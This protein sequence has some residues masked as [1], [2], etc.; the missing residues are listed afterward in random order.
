M[1]TRISVSTPFVAMKPRSQIRPG[2]QK[3]GFY[4]PLMNDE[5]RL[6][7]LDRGSEPIISCKVVHVPLSQDPVF[8][9]LSYTWGSL[10]NKEKILVNDTPFP[11]T[12]NLFEALL[13]IRKQVR[14][15]QDKKTIPL[16]WIDAICLDQGDDREKSIE[17]PRMSLIYGKCERV[18]VWIGL[19]NEEEEKAIKK[20]VLKLQMLNAMAE[21]SKKTVETIIRAYS[22]SNSGPMAAEHSRLLASLRNIGASPWFK[23]IWY[24]AFIA[25]FK[26]TQLLK[27]VLGQFKRLH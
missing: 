7:R 15:L 10:S 25:A 17:V 14:S 6:I 2:T 5:I 3:A 23:R 22:N 27:T 16:L 12:L 1:S 8:W 24:V 11:V 9:A 20:V 13:E 4:K 26:P 21:K 19:V 18:L